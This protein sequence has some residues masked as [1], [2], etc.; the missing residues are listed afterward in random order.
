MATPKSCS[1]CE[2]RSLGR[3][4]LSGYSCTTE[5]M[6]PTVCGVDYK[7]WAPRLG[8]WQRIK[9]V[10]CGVKVEQEAAGHEQ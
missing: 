2:H 10:W 1:T 3:C 4:M 6:Y 8:V 7:R 5:R 9:A